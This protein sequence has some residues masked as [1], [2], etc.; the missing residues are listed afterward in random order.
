[1]E[2]TPGDRNFELTGSLPDMD[3]PGYAA[4]FVRVSPDGTRLAVGNNG[5]SS[6]ANY[7]V[8]VFSVTN[9]AGAWFP[10]AHY[11]AEWIDNTYLA[12]TAGV[13]GQPSIVTAL[14][15]SSTPATPLNSTIVENIGGSSAGITFDAAGNLYTGN[16]YVGAGPSDTGWI[17]VFA[18]ADWMPALSGG[19]AVDFEIGGT[20][21]GDLL[22]AGSLGFDTEGNLHVGGGDFLGGSE[23]GNAA[24]VRS[25]ALADALAGGGPIDPLDPALV[26]RFDPDAENPANYYDA[27]FN[28]VTGEVYLRDGAMVYAF[29]V[30]EPS[31]WMLACFVAAFGIRR[32][33]KTA[34]R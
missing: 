5:G 33:A 24:L 7:E 16:G 9:L 26:R 8:G 2:A 10:A 34:R 15:T 17:K 12:L 31:C 23:H 3:V 13:W 6:W 21:I 30:P 18:P 25:S 20:L 14:D 11:E 1:V 4:A 29:A 22:S 19:T 27:N 28:A 32:R